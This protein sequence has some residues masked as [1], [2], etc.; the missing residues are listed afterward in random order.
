MP[1][2]SARTHD[3]LLDDLNPAQRAAVTYPGSWLLILAGAGS[4][5]TR[6][7]TR[8]AAWLIQQGVPPQAVL[9]VTFTRKAAE[10]LAGRLHEL[11]GPPGAPVFTSTFHAFGAWL[12]RHAAPVGR[13]TSFS[14]FDAEDTRKALAALVKGQDGAHPNSA[15][16]AV[17]RLKQYGPGTED[18]WLRDLSERYE[19]RLREA[20]AV[21]FDDLIRL[22]ALAL[23]SHPDLRRSVTDRFRHVLVD[24]Y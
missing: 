12:L 13:D 24:E 15:V 5:K 7:L 8:R 1:F 6:M 3:P 19:A 9:C 22:P 10:E 4:G 17:R 21:D 14:I 11:L 18:P 20:N 16:E 23:E 2:P